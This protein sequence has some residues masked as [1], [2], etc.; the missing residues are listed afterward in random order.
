MEDNAVPMIEG[1]D[2]SPVELFEVLRDIVARARAADIGEE[3]FVAMVGGAYEAT[4]DLRNSPGRKALPGPPSNPRNDG[5][6][7]QRSNC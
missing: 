6:E 3:D 4:S 1:A 2:G 7:A 5:A